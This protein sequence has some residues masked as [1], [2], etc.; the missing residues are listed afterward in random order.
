[1]ISYQQSNGSAPCAAELEDIGNL[2]F[3]AGLDITPDTTEQ[4][5]VIPDGQDHA[6]GF[7]IIPGDVS[8]QGGDIVV[9]LNVTTLSDPSAFIFAEAFFVT[10]EDSSCSFSGQEVLLDD[11]DAM[12]QLSQGVNQITMS[13]VANPS[14]FGTTDKI[15]IIMYLANFFSSG[16][17]TVGITPSET[18]VLPFNEPTTVVQVDV[19]DSGSGSDNVSVIKE[20]QIESAEQATGQDSVSVNIHAK[21]EDSGTFSESDHINV[22]F[23]VQ[24]IAEAT[25]DIDILLLIFKHVQ[26]SFSATD[27]ASKTSILLTIEDEAHGSEDIKCQISVIIEDNA[28]FT[29]QTTLVLKEIIKRIADNAQFID[30]SPHLGIEFTVSDNGMGSD[31]IGAHIEFTVTDQANVA[32]NIEVITDIIISI[33]DSGSFS[34]EGGVDI[35]GLSVKDSATLSDEIGEA[36]VYIKSRESA[37]FQ[38]AIAEISNMLA[39]IEEATAT[40]AVIAFEEHSRVLEITFQLKQKMTIFNLTMKSMDYMFKYKK[41]EFEYAY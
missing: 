2:E 37:Q 15:V 40:D 22:S 9:N 24:D 17:V 19:T 29:D 7:E 41:M 32:D 3:I 5:V 30:S 38:D 26:D 21:V 23:F 31:D 18:I 33:L 34:D 16:D 35:V 12:V 13:G 8:T 20:A 39:I 27:G 11:L 4:Q 28:Q 10:K 6:I 36:S 1:M 25:D 14:S